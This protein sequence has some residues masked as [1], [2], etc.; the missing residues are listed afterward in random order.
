MKRKYM[1]VVSSTVGK[2]IVMNLEA[3][4]SIRFLLKERNHA[5]QTEFKGIQAFERNN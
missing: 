1:W 5:L 3:S 2:S 4:R